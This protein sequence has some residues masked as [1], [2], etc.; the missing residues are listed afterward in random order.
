MG[1]RDIFRASQNVIESIQKIVTDNQEINKKL[2]TAGGFISLIGIVIDI[3]SDI[4]DRLKTPEER[5]FGSL[6]RVTFQSTE[7]LLN[8]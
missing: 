1:L 6:I 4:K 5:A 2:E 7:E 3:Y 8:E